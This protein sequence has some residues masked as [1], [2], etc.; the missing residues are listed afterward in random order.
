MAALT[1]NRETPRRASPDDRRL[2]YAP[3]AS[4][5]FYIGGIVA[6]DTADSKLKPGATSTTLVAVGVCAERYTSPASVPSTKYVKLMTGTHRFDNSA[7]ADLIALDDIGK[8]CYIVDD[9]TV[10]LTNGGATRSIAG[11]IEDVD[12]SGV[13]VSFRPFT[14]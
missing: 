2:A 1:A 7:A 11:R 13:W 8:V 4:D 6:V 10:A 12:S 14:G 9:Q 5:E 3:V